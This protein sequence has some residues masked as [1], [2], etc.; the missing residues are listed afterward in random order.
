MIRQYFE[1]DFC[2]LGFFLPDDLIRESL[3][4][5][6]SQTVI[7]PNDDTHRFTTVPLIHNAYLNSFF[8]S[9]LVYFRNKTQPH[10]SVLKIKLKELI[11]NIIYSDENHALVSYLKWVTVNKELSLTHIMESNY[12]Y[13]LSLEQYA[14]MC[15]RSLS[16][17]KRDF[18]NHYNTT[19]GKW[20]YSKRLDHAA[21]LLRSTDM[22]ITEI[23]FE[24]GFEDVSHFSRSFKEK[25][26]VSPSR[27]NNILS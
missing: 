24:C 22:N 4:D 3:A 5:V 17:F 18:L 26:G 23:T 14:K 11:A 21:Q 20:L 6:V 27:Y 8:Q 9:M 1:D 10:D 12:C 7:S 16:T 25:F 19:P 13:N 15:H 2:M